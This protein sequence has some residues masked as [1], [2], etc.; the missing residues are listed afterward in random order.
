[1]KSK[2]GV[3]MNMAT[4]QNVR[5]AAEIETRL[6]F[7]TKVFEFFRIQDTTGRMFYDYDKVLTTKYKIDW[8]AFYTY[9]IKTVEKRVLPMPKYFADN[10][11]AFKKV[12][13]HVHADDGSLIVI[14]L[15]DGTELQFTVCN[16]FD[17][18][19]SLAEV[20]KR[21]SKP[22]AKARI[23]KIV[24][25]PKGTVVRNGQMFFDTFI[26]NWEKLSADE[27][28]KAEAE[29]EKEALSKVKVIYRRE[30]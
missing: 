14:K 2:K 9:I 11:K 25:Y 28:A 27:L 15:S 19:T 5:P 10:V 6:E 12:E 8:A 3:L 29:K 16:N 21:F 1:M 22:D 26:Y 4:N 23:V 18:K 30:V 13:E 24:Q 17:T 20:K 7:I